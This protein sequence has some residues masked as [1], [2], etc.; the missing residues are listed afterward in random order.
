VDKKEWIKILGD[1]IMKKNLL[2]TLVI[3]LMFLVGT[4]SATVLI[5][6]NADSLTLGEITEWSNEGTTGGTFL[7]GVPADPNIVV[8]TVD[9]RQ[10][11][12]FDGN[13]MQ[14]NFTTPAALTGSNPWS[15][16]VWAYE[17]EPAW[18]DCMVQWADRGVFGCAQFNFGGLALTLWDDVVYTNPPPGNE[19]VHL[20]ATYDGATVTVY[21]NGIVDVTAAKSLNIT[22]DCYMRLAIA[23]PDIYGTHPFTGSLARVQMHDRV[24]TK[25][26]I[27][28]FIGVFEAGTYAP[29][30]Q[31]VTEGTSGEITIQ[32]NEN[33][34]TA[35]GPSSD[36]EVTLSI[37][38]NDTDIYFESEA[39]GASYTATIPAS[40]W[41]TPVS[42]TVTAVD[43]TDVEAT[44]DITVMA[45]IT[46][47]D[48][49]Y[50][51]QIMVPPSGIVV[52][53]ID[54]DWAGPCDLPTPVDGFFI[55]PFECPRD[56][57]AHGV[58]GSIWTGFMGF[59]EGQGA[60]TIDDS[61]SNWG[62]LTMSSTNS[63]W[64]GNDQSGP[65]L[66]RTIIGDFIAETYIADYP[67]LDNPDNAIYHN[68][69]GIMV[70]VPVL[71][72]AGPGE[73][74]VQCSY[75]PVWDVGNILRY[76]DDG[77]RWEGDQTFDAF[78]ADRYLQVERRG[79]DIYCRHSPDGVNWTAFPTANPL[80][81]ADFDG[82]PLQVGL[83]QAVYS[84]EIGWVEYEYFKVKQS[85]GEISGSATL[86]EA[87]EES[88]D[89]TVSIDTDNY[90]GAPLQDV[91]VT[92]TPVGLG[93]DPNSNPEDVRLGAA[94]PGESVDVTFTTSDWMTPKTVTATAVNDGLK[95]D[96]QLIGISYVV[97]S[98]DPNFN[99][100]ILSNLVQ[101][102]ILDVGIIMPR[103]AEVWEGGASDSITVN[104]GSSPDIGDVTVNIFDTS[105]PI[106][107]IASPPE[108]T[109]T[110]ENWMTPQPVTLTA[111]DDDILE[112]DPHWTWLEV[113]A[114]A[115]AGSV[116]ELIEDGFWMQIHDNECGAWNYFWA[117]FDQDCVITISDFAELAA[118]WMLC[119]TPNDPE[120]L[121]LR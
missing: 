66:Y 113:D 26:E 99:E 51:G 18:E 81:R 43:D 67:G 36:V 96:T 103:E 24:L 23:L 119:T 29:E 7:K 116:Y 69:C 5:D 28:A 37:V 39:P 6:L 19:W 62:V 71:E 88:T 70:R 13:Y 21:I 101:I 8:E 61:L 111:V 94:L 4:A 17:P 20:A 78:A 50:L 98:G 49:D 48:S 102:Q 58:E 95:E 41:D 91:V 74:D 60:I 2:I 89:I 85:V 79:N 10:A 117:D 44:N 73:D 68:D 22:A 105:N 14:S 32:L 54:D 108:L 47:G 107:V 3:S 12:T 90:I 75:F 27:Q 11:V 55:D 115:T 120:C 38:D 72:D 82:L 110:S 1:T 35:S 45:E 93:D 83:Q 30:T 86:I 104:L 64:N 118:Q 97:T 25:E 112:G 65:F 77:V 15:V 106:N 76:N 84:S 40:S 92:I 114:A 63:S 46:G 87:L 109:F 16:M 100:A 53:V 31:D 9:G 121:D 59:D 33:P 80:T 56:F 57:D 52:S 34:N 42:V